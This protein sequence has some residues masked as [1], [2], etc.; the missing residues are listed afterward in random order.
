LEGE[1]N[2]S[3]NTVLKNCESDI[4]LRWAHE[5]DDNALYQREYLLNNFSCE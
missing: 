3:H 1:N 5:K 2:D 4:G